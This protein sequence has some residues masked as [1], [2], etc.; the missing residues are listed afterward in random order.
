[1]CQVLFSDVIGLLVGKV[2]QALQLNNPKAEKND[3]YFDILGNNFN[4]DK[5]QAL[6]L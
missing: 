1:M 3:Y 4:Y 2:D 5:Y 6:F